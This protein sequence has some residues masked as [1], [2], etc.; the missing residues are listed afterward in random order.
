MMLKD[1]HLLHMIASPLA[2]REV[3]Q[4]R[5]G[6]ISSFADMPAFPL[7][8]ECWRSAWQEVGLLQR[9]MKYLI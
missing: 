1:Q 5:K 2:W 8:M 6:I 7:A 9:S 4:A 3:G